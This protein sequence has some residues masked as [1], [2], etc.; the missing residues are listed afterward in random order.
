MQGIKILSMAPYLGSKEIPP[1]NYRT[2]VIDFF[3]ANLKEVT[4]KLK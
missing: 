2:N 1:S 4:N 3:L